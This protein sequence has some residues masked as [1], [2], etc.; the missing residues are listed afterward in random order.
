[1]I[2]TYNSADDIPGLFESLADAT[3][4]RSVRTVVVDNCSTDGTLET[5]K[6]CGASLVIDS[7]RNLGYAGGINLGR[8]A[9]REAGPTDSF[10]VLNPD[11]RLEPGAIDHMLKIIERPDVGAVV[12]RLTNEQG[13]TRHSQ[14]RE[15]SIPRAFGEAVF[16]ARLAGRP[17]WLSEEVRE[18]WAYEQSIPVD[19]A[20]GAAILVS[21]EVD[22]IVGDW[23]ETFFM[24]SEEVDYARRIRSSGFSIM[25]APG[26]VASHSEGGS[27]QSPELTALL[28]L[29]RIRAYANTHGRFSVAV[30]RLIVVGWELLRFRQPGRLYA[31]RVALGV[32]SPPSF[33]DAPQIAPVPW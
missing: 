33:R 20:T 29:N 31:A 6:A 8:R 24:Y 15:P 13:D 17:S 2:V 10:L 23:D 4:D 18:G 16:G 11:L 26:A 1:M 7:G 19:W 14:R 25:Y 5:A 28:A 3:G 30:Y 21:S 32:A 22:E 9:A 27:G 12:P